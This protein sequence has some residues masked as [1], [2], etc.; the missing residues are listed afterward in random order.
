MMKDPIVKEV[1]RA[2]EELAKRA[3]YS[4]HVLFQNLRN[5]KKKAEPK[6]FRN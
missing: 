5:N 6:W 4:L 3:N 1:R 2:G